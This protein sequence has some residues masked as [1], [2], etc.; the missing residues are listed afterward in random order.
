MDEVPGNKFCTH[1]LES[2]DDVSAASS[3]VN[4]LMVSSPAPI[5][6]AK[7]RTLL[8]LLQVLAIVEARQ[9]SSIVAR[10]R[11]IDCCMGLRLNRLKGTA[12]L[13]IRSL[14]ARYSALC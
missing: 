7:L 11:A 2:T 1:G 10:L 8:A 4:I 6:R 12:S 14:N 3:R 9:W 13:P 5:P